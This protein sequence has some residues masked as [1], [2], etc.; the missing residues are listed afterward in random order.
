[1]IHSNL[2]YNILFLKSQNKS[3]NKQNINKINLKIIM[4]GL[5]STTWFFYHP[6]LKS[7]ICLTFVLNVSFIKE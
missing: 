4:F 1:M 5:L 2:V 6:S 7:A 3:K